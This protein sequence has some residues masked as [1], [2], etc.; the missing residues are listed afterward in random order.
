[1]F[2]SFLFSRYPFIV[3]FFLLVGLLFNIGVGAGY[4]FDDFSSVW[5]L[6]DLRDSPELFWSLVQNDRSGPLGRPVTIITFA[7]EQLLFH[8]EPSFSQRVSIALHTFNGLLV[9]IIIKSL[10]DS[11]SDTCCY[12]VPFFLAAIWVLAPQKVSSVLYIVQ[13]MAVFATTFVLLAVC[14]YVKARLAK[15]PAYRS[16][17]FIASLLS[18]LLAPFAKENGALAVP[19]IASAEI[20][21][22]NNLWEG[23]WNKRIKLVCFAIF[24]GFIAS[25]L[26]Y[27]LSE[28]ISTGGVYPHR[29]FNF[30]DRVLSAPAILLDYS[31]QF[32]FPVI[33]EMGVIHDDYPLGG[34]GYRPF[35]FAVGA[36]AMIASVGL[37]VVSVWRKIMGIPAF[38]VAFFLIGHSIES[39]YLP[40]EL[41]FEHR[42]YLPSAGLSFAIAPVV[43]FLFSQERKQRFLAA[44]FCFVYLAFMASSTARLCRVWVSSEA[45]LIHHLN[46]HP[47]SA[48]ANADYAWFAAIAGDIRVAKNHLELADALSHEEPASKPFGYADVALQHVLVACLSGQPLE[49]ELPHTYKTNSERHL[50]SSTLRVLRRIYEDGVCPRADW[51]AVSAWIEGFVASKV[52]AGEPISGLVLRD[53]VALERSLDNTLRVFIYTGMAL[54]KRPD[55]GMLHLARLQAAAKVQDIAAMRESVVSLERLLAQGRL[56]PLEARLFVGAKERGNLPE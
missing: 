2:S 28:Y 1:M 42:N 32:F 6:R 17:L 53:L 26:G 22:L 38:G 46:G 11:R 24:L 19:I 8:A 34:P 21:A 18:V 43:G 35:S 39:F 7:L 48:R 36:F 13:R 52:N 41:Y 31:K 14:F 33:E 10:L 55:D 49:N 40:L 50:S 16:V 27:G 4:L 56:R 47:R 54:E 37:L 5:P 15:K 12:F 29:S 23:K 30:S 9:F 51:N 45:L 44:V 3:V 25:F 20:F